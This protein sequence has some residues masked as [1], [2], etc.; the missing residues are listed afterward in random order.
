MATVAYSKSLANQF[1]Q[2]EDGAATPSHG[3]IVPGGFEY[4]MP[5]SQVQPGHQPQPQPRLSTSTRP[6]PVSMPPQS[7]NAAAAAI[8]SPGPATDDRASERDK[9]T[10][11]RDRDRER[12]RRHV[13]SSRTSRSNRILGDYTLSKTLGAGSMGKVKLATHNMTGEQVVT[14]RYLVL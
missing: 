9:D 14:A 7:F 4:D 2:Y 3:G 12:E 5:I 13:P 1:N 6:R 11:D 8:P 10:R